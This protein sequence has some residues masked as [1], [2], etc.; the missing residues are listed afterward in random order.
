MRIVE[1]D[2]VCD[3][4]MTSDL[5]RLIADLSKHLPGISEWVQDREDLL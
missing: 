4:Q 5:E 1:G 3:V 2:D